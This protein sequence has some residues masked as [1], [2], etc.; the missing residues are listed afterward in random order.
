MVSHVVFP[1]KPLGDYEL[2]KIQPMSSCS[3]LGGALH[4]TCDETGMTVQARLC[5]AEAFAV[6]AKELRQNKGVG[7]L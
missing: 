7:S 1:G 6:V 3:I 4:I 5:S 2:F